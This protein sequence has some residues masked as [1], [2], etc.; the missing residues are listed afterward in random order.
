MTDMTLHGNGDEDDV[1]RELRAM[2]SAPTEDAY[3]TELEARIMNRVGELGLGWWG[4]LDRWVRPALLAAA[5]LVLAAGV[6]MFRA[7]QDETR[8]AYDAILQPASVPVETAIRPAF[9]DDRQATVR[10]L[11]TH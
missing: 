11:F 8:I 3:W 4:E 9:Q 2:Y 7:R 5:V 6:A 1:A 10:F